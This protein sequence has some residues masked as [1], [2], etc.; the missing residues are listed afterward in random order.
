MKMTPELE[1]DMLVRGSITSMKSKGPKIDLTSEV[2]DLLGKEE[3]L[4]ETC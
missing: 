3:S 2:T 1:I 4:T